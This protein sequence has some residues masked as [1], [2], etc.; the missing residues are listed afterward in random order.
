M[1][2]VR[3]KGATPKKGLSDRSPS[4][5]RPPGA[6]TLY[7]CMS[8]PRVQGR[9]P[10]SIARRAM[11]KLK[12]EPWPTSTLTPRARA[13]S[14]IGWTFPVSPE[15]K[16]SGMTG[17]GM[18]EDIAG[19]EQRDGLAHVGVG[20]DRDPVPERPELPEV[21]VDGDPRPPGDRLGE[22]DHLD[23]PARP[24]ANLRVGLDPL[25]EVAV[26][27]DRPGRVLDVH[28]VR[29]VELR[30]AVPLEPADEIGGDEAEDPAPGPLRDVVAETRD[31]HAARAAL[32]DE[33]GDPGPDPDE[34]RIEPEPP[35]DVLV[36]VGVGVD[37]PG[38]HQLAGRIDAP[39]S[40]IGRQARLHRRDP[41]GADRDVESSGSTRR[42][43]DQGAAGHGDV[44]RPFRHLLPLVVAPRTP[45]RGVPHR[46]AASRLAA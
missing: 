4:L 9:I 15:T 16:P 2:T 38:H 42:G 28:P 25:D 13:S 5:I 19:I 45:L 40:A 39:G 41:A 17:E 46:R 29:A 18:G 7:P 8:A 34:V 3:L 33:G 32:V 26:L 36:H 24:A 44:K 6:R 10:A 35:R 20:V 21:D 11:S 27:L 12:C 23:A 31:G 14:M 43:V 22:L 30:I 1:A 37:E